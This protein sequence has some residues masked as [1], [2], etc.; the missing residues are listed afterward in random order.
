MAVLFVDDGST[1]MAYTPALAD[2]DMTMRPKG[3][4]NKVSGREKFPHYYAVDEATGCWNWTRS[5]SNKG[6]GYFRRDGH[7]LA[8]R[9][10]Y[11]TFVG[12]IPPKMFVLHHCDNPRCVNPDHLFL[13]TN[14]DNILDMVA[15]GR[16]WLQNPERI[17]DGPVYFRPGHKAWQ[18]IKKGIS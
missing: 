17:S 4:P 15:K 9:W 11:G 1:S 8:H 2:E 16:H 12:P 7:E 6:Y 13:G 14:H 18:E 5:L 3:L 10:S